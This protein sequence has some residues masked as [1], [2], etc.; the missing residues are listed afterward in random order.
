[1]IEQAARVLLAAGALAW[2]YALVKAWRRGAR[3]SRL[4]LAPLAFLL[5]DAWLAVPA[6]C[7]PRLTF[8]TLRLLSPAL[9]LAAF[10][11]SRRGA[12]FGWLAHAGALAAAALAARSLWSVRYGLGGID[13]FAYLDFARDALDGVA[14][15]ARQR[16]VYF[17]GVYLFWEAALLAASR[18]L[19]GV[20]LWF[21]GTLFLG[22]ALCGWAVFRVT[23]SLPAALGAG[24]IQL[25]FGLTLEARRGMTEAIA[26]IPLLAGVGAWAGAPLR[27]RDGLLRACALGAGL[28]ASIFFKQQVALLSLGWLALVALRAGGF[29]ELFAVPLSAVLALL[30]LLV[31]TGGLD[32]LRAGLLLVKSYPAEGSFV[33]N[34]A[35]LAPALSPLL[36]YGGLAAAAALLLAVRGFDDARLRA[37]AFCLLAAAVSLLQLRTRAYIHY[38]LL[39]LPMLVLGIACMGQLLLEKL[40]Q[41]A[42]SAAVALAALAAPV[43]VQGRASLPLL[44]Q[45]T[46]LHD[47]PYGSPAQPI[48]EEL[49]PRARGLGAFVIPPVNGGVH[50]LLGTR[51]LGWP[52]AYFWG[53][54]ETGDASKA[55]QDPQ[56]R[57]VVVRRIFGRQVERQVCAAAGCDAAL[58]AL[59]ALGYQRLIDSPDVIVWQR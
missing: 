37:A 10:F 12:R 16:L 57:L 28:G 42:A 30:L 15:T 56:V 53:A 13:F 51:A 17:P 18:A 58:A 1:M 25:V 48:L 20:Q 34:L 26:L 31:P 55:V 23:R 9:A 36:L 5:V 3:D 11:A 19:P 47:W 7:A 32:A 41:H 40:P 21:A 2:G 52:Q 49:A 33:G 54:A 24:A 27:G 14:A 39:P 44:T 59:P 38:T 43:L 29:R 50:F 4:L 8:A 6:G 22:A 46:A 35:F 45:A